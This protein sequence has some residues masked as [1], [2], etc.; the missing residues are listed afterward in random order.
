MGFWTV[1]F[2]L[3][4]GIIFYVGWRGHQAFRGVLKP[5]QI[6]L[7]WVVYA[8]FTSSFVLAE[9]LGLSDGVLNEGL[10]WLGGYSLAFIYYAFLLL[11][12]IDIIR[13]ADRW[14]SIIPHRIKHAPAEVGLF[15]LVILAGLLGYGTWNAFHPVYVNYDIYITKDGGP[16]NNVHAVMV[17]DLHLGVIVNKSRLEKLVTSI[18]SRHPDIVFLVGDVVDENRKPFVEENMAD[19]LG[20]IK[21]PLGVYMVTGN[22]DGHGEDVTSYLKAAGVKLLSDQNCLVG[23][24]FYLVGRSTRQH[25]VDPGDRPALAEVMKGIDIKR[26]IILLDHNPANLDDAQNNKVD[27]Q[28]SGHTH[29]GQLFPNNYITGSIYDIDWGYL[30]KC[31]LQV[32]VST[33]FGTWGPP[34]RIGNTPEIVDLHIR[35]RR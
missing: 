21:P 4:C 33:G 14:W 30:K 22:H 29:Q 6:I 31:D 15:V 5:R 13:L 7:Y 20:Q 32:V 17:S 28:L 2:F 19:V 24:S 16:I 35:F 9:R 12:L 26:P 10:S 34:I 23:D 1:V 27:L 8:F 25:G 11:V 3:M 18:N